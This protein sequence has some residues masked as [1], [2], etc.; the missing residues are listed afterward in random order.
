MSIK[1]VRI[2]HNINKIE[3]NDHNFIKFVIFSKYFSKLW[4]KLN[5]Y[6][7]EIFLKT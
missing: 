6:K 3:K 4:I 7:S 1:I 5:I 2:I